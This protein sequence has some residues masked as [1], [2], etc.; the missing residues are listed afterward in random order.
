MKKVLV[1][2]FL[3]VFN[4]TATYNSL[5]QD[6]TYV[7]LPREVAEFYYSEYTITIPFLKDEIKL[8]EKQLEGKERQLQALDSI[9]AVQDTSIELY[10]DNQV[11]YSSQSDVFKEEIKRLKKVIL[12]YKVL[13]ALAIVLNV[14]F[15]VVVLI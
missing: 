11:D 13:I 7:Y 6:T 4:L 12:K 14:A 15:L 8:K 5:A 10:K 3:I 9:I 2:I 1:Y